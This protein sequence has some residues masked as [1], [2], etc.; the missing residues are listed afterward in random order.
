MRHA[1]IALA[2]LTTPA[3]AVDPDNLTQE[4]KRLFLKCAYV[5]HQR[6]TSTLLNAVDLTG[7][8][9]MDLEACAA[10]EPSRF[11]PAPPE[12]VPTPTAAPNR[13]A[14]VADRA[15]VCRRHGLRKVVNGNSWRCR[16]R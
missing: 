11:D 8:N 3:L 6:N 10:S 7:W 2:L 14:K 16:R 15:D 4:D 13:G 1:L 9:A 12:P 5:L